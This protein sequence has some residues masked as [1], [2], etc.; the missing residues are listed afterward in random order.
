MQDLRTSL[1]ATRWW[2]KVVVMNIM[3]E[4]E[5]GVGEDCHYCWDL[6]AYLLRKRNGQQ[7]LS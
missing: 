4:V 6:L 1:M 5:I 3:F 2:R 7:Q